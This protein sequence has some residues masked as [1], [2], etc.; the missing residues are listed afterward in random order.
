MQRNPSNLQFNFKLISNC[1][2]FYDFY[3]IFIFFTPF[4]FNFYV[5]FKKYIQCDKFL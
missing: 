5:Y 1:Y 3:P 4:D 2:I